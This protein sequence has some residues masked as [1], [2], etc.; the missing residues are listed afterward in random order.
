MIYEINGR[1]VETDR[2][3]TEAEIDEIASQIGA[4]PAAQEFSNPLAQTP[5][6]YAE[7]EPKKPGIMEAGKSALK[8]VANLAGMGA[9][10][11][12]NPAESLLAPAK[13]GLRQST[14]SQKLG[15]EVA[16][17][18]GRMGVPAPISAALGL[19]TSVGT[20][21]LTYAPAGALSKTASKAVSTAESLTT[22]AQKNLQ[23]ITAKAS[24][25]LSKAKR[26]VGLPVTAE[27]QA[28]AIEEVGN[29]FNYGKKDIQEIADAIG[30]ENGGAIADRLFNPKIK[31]SKLTGKGKEVAAETVEEVRSFARPDLVKD[32][33][34][35][36]VAINRFKRYSDQLPE[37]PRLKLAASLQNKINEFVNWEKTGNQTEGVLKQMYGDLKELQYPATLKESKDE[38]ASVL[39][40]AKELKP[41]KGKPGAAEAYLKRVLTGSN[42]ANKD[43]IKALTSL[44]QMTGEPIIDA[45]KQAFADEGP[46]LGGEII[47]GVPV[48]GPLWNRLVKVVENALDRPSFIQML[49]RSNKRGNR[50]ALV[51][52]GTLAQT[53]PEARTELEKIKSRVNG[54]Q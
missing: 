19:A 11:T 4:A 27:E 8:S 21:P 15:G 25:K 43:K 24:E 42:A 16:E 32:G 18:G 40:L 22:K 54:G 41:L 2:E 1:E 53:N 6:Q 9:A 46:S 49:E 3:L 30:G 31:S 10:T 47:R 29:A 17:Q 13:V 45:L 39:N 7:D 28:K 33:E 12:M 26:E 51:G 5:M 34:D 20:D 48:A 52:L 50:A 38:M 23:T 44:E 14:L 36:V 37:G 35:L